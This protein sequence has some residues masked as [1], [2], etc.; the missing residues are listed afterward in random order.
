MAEEIVFES[1][2][3]EKKQTIK[4]WLIPAAMML[5]IILIAAAL[6]F[7]FRGGG[8]KHTGGEET[9]YPYT[10]RAGKNGVISLELDRSAAPGYLW[11][12]S[13]AGALMSVAETQDAEKSRTIFTLTPQAAGRTVLV[14]SLQR[15]GDAAD[16]IYEISA[17][18]ETDE[19][20]RSLSSELLSISGKPLLGTVRGGEDT[21]YPY[22]VRMDEDGD[23][24]LAIAD[25]TSPAEETGQKDGDA[26]RADQ[27]DA[28][29]QCTSEDAGIAEVLGV[30]TQES[31]AV[32]YLRS[33]PQP[34][35]V[36]VHMTDSISGTQLNLELETDGSGE[37]RL[38]SHSLNVNHQG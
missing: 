19:S 6:A 37:I 24:L 32:A 9:P 1:E 17:L 34:G 31:G 3:Y 33:G 2:R 30:I 28:G 27:K 14:F 16:R 26:E 23:L 5:A 20:G 21:D 10:W 22:L 36:R 4:R 18:A 13:D 12:A 38:L 11:T 8:R 35:T 29:W 15:E 25:N 7:F